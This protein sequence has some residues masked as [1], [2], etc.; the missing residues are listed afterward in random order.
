M[1]AVVWSES[2]VLSIQS[3]YDFIYIRSP[4]N[5]EFVVDTLFDIGDN[6]NKFTDRNPKDPIFN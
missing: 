5:A 6:L 1:K 2:A 4:K 3:I